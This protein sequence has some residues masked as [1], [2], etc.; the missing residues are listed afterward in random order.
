MKIRVIFPNSAKKPIFFEISSPCAR[1]TVSVWGQYPR[2][3]G[4]KCL[5]LS[6]NSRGRG[7]GRIDIVVAVCR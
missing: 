5:E 6:K 3:A 1:S 4:L 2:F 7:N